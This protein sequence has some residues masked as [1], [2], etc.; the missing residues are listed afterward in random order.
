MLEL[1]VNL[2]GSGKQYI[3]DSMENFS[4]PISLDEVTEVA[5]MYKTSFCKYYKI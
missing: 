4:N 5:S 2:K 1:V 3:R